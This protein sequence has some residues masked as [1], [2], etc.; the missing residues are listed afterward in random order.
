MLPVIS[1]VK[2]IAKLSPSQISEL[3]GDQTNAS[4]H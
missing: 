3:S 4:K 2:G 1:Q